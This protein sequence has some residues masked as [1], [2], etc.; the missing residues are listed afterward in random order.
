MA[1]FTDTDLANIRTIIG[2]ATPP[3]DA[4]L[5]EIF[6]RVE[7][8]PGVAHEVLSKRLADLLAS[9]ATFSVSGVYSQSTGDNIRAL[10]EA[11]AQMADAIPGGAPGGIG[12]SQVIIVD[13]EVPCGR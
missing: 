1:E 12:M 8:W 9:P 2:D 10:K 6:T 11:I 3:E 13:P 4:D 5:E 7:S